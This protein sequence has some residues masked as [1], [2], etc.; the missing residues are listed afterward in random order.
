[1]YRQCYEES[2]RFLSRTACYHAD[3]PDTGS[4]QDGEGIVVR[5]SPK[6]RRLDDN[7]YPLADVQ[8]YIREHWK[9]FSTA[10][11]K[12]GCEEADSFWEWHDEFCMGEYPENFTGREMGIVGIQPVEAYFYKSFTIGKRIFETEEH[13]NSKSKTSNC[14][15]IFQT[16]STPA[17]VF[18]R[19]QS[20]VMMQVST[21]LC[22]SSKVNSKCI[23]PHVIHLQ[24]E[25]GSELF[26]EVRRLRHLGEH[27]HL[28]GVQVVSPDPNDR[29]FFVQ[30]HDIREQIFFS[31]DLTTGE[32]RQLLV[33]RKG[34]LWTMD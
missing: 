21:G 20:I 34:N 9:E 32:T 17:E 16:E 5:G 19:I 6:R 4:S 26:I 14:G 28:S 11:E 33:H 22:L 31:R 2:L 23:I 30:I 1:M 24:F 29:T 18:G 15:V 27:K 8:R 13:A 7:G 3:I 25:H 10:A 12:V